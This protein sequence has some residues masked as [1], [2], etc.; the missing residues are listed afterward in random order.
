MSDRDVLAEAFDQNRTH[1]QAVA[2]R[3]LGSQTEAEDAVQE[4]WMRLRGTDAAVV[5]N[6]TAWLTTV[7]GRG[8]STC[9]ESGVPAARKSAGRGS[10]SPTFGPPR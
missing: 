2:Y 8:A 4:T 10:P 5:N 1:P 6:L 9:S 7:V 3:M